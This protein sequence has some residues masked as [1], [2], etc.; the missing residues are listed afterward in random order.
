LAKVVFDLRHREQAQVT[1][2]TPKN[3]E[4]PFDFME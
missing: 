4:M 2:G 1:G 3:I